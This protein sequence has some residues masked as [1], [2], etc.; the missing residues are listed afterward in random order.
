M[1]A[2]GFG[3]QRS[4]GQM[5]HVVSVCT[6]CC[7]VGMLLRVVESCCIKFE[8]GQTFSYVQTD[9]TTPNEVLCPFAGS[10]KALF[11]VCSDPLCLNLNPRFTML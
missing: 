11:M 10:F 4:F 9:A 2:T 3:L 8:T 7:H 5:L 6:P 1:D